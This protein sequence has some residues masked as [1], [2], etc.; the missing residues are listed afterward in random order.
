MEE[1]IKTRWCYACPN[2]STEIP[3]EFKKVAEELKRHYKH[4]VYCKAYET[5]MVA[6]DK[7]TQVADKLKIC[8]WFGK[9]YK[10]PE[11]EEVKD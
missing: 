2:H 9:E 1:F 11:E 5:L 7:P 4:V 8:E 3:E 6:G 10:P